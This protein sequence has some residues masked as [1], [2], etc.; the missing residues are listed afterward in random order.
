VLSARGML[1]TGI[2]L[3]TVHVPVSGYEI[4]QTA[5]PEAMVSVDK[6]EKYF[7]TVPDT[8]AFDAIG[9]GPGLG[10]DK[11]TVKALGDLLEKAHRPLVLDADA[12]N[13]IGA[14]R[15]LLQII[16]KGSILTPH[17]KEF[18]RIAG[19]SKN[20]FARLERQREFSQA[21]SVVVIGKGAF[22]SITSPKGTVYFNNTGN[23]GMATGGSGD[24][25][26][27]VLTALLA[28][29]YDSLECA[30]L[31]VWLHG[32][33]GDEAA[34]K[35]GMWGMSASDIIDHLPDAFRQLS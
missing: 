21:H 11:I 17:Q 26:T 32:L 5:V 9:I 6:A 22:T 25:L 20:D 7:S 10:L 24:V 19:E 2:G 29:G 12:L 1:R 14:H 23:P 35:R 33:A 28:Q 18:E 4:I 8:T 30:Q 16:P 13:I 34:R 3:I 31:S 27:G 15:E